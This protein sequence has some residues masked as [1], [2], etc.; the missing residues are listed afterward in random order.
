MLVRTARGTEEHFSPG[1]VVLAAPGAFLAGISRV[2]LDDGNARK[3]GL[4]PQE[5]L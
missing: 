1:F 3:A 2:H 4:V 5:L